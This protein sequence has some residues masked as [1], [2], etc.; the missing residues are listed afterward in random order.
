MKKYIFSL[1]LVFLQTLSMLGDDQ[2]LFTKAH[3]NFVQGDWEG[4]LRNYRAITDKNSVVW[5]N[6]GICYFNQQQYAHALLYWQ[7]AYKDCTLVQIGQLCTLEQRALEKLDFKI[8]S[9][10]HYFCKRILLIIPLIFLQ[11]LFAIM[12]C[13]ML[14]TL[15]RCWRWKEIVICDRRWLRWIFLGCFLCGGLWYANRSFFQKN[16]AIV[17]KRDVLVYAGPERTFHMVTTL[18]QGS[19]VNVIQKKHG[20]YNITNHSIAGWVMQDTVEFIYN[21][22]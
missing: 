12:L 1:L 6:I 21:Y 3:E 7:R 20:M 10:G 8:P 2:Q 19:S 14:W 4:A 11:T 5:Q 17:V 22:E 16:Q 15:A 13:C 18:R 9:R